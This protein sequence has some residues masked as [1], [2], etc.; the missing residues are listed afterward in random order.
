MEVANWIGIGLLILMTLFFYCILISHNRLKHHDSEDR[1]II[2]HSEDFQD[3]AITLEL[4]DNDIQRFIS[5]GP[6]TIKIE[7]RAYK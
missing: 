4:E 3:F 1:I 6:E 2:Y 5:H 7:R